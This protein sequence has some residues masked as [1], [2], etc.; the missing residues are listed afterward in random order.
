MSA[1]GSFI[2]SRSRKFLP[3]SILPSESYRL[4]LYGLLSGSAMRQQV[5]WHPHTRQLLLRSASSG[6]ISLTKLRHRGSFARLPH[7]LNRFSSWNFSKK[8]QMRLFLL[9]EL[10][11]QVTVLDLHRLE[12]EENQRVAASFF[13]QRLYRDMFGHAEVRQLRNAVVFDEA[14]RVA[15][16]TLIPKMMQECRKYGIL[17]CSPRNES[18]ISTRACSI[19][20][21][22]ISICEST[23]RMRGGSPPIWQRVVERVT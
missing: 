4:V 11:S 17:L 5:L 2:I 8:D 16:L 13:L 1:V 19:A 15:R 6:R 7:A 3:I 18:R 23:T 9:L 21:V 20:Q 22:T 12:I 10:L 14:H